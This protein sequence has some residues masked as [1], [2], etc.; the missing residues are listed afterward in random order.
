VRVSPFRQ[1]VI[2]NLIGRGSV[3]LLGIAFIPL[4]LRF[5]GI[6]AYGLV[7]FY[8]MLQGVLGLLDLGLGATINRELARLSVGGDRRADQRAILRTLEACYWATSLAAGIAIVT[9]ATPIARHWVNPSHLSLEVVASALRLMGFVIALQF[10]FS[11]YQSAMLGLQRQ[12]ALNGVVI[13]TATIRS[14]GTALVLWKVSATIEAF[15]VCQVAVSVLQTGWTAALVWSALGG[16]FTTTPDASRLRDVKGYA[17]A[18]SASSLIGIA[19][20]QLDKVLLTKLLPLEQFGYYALAG[21]MASF[22]WAIAIPVHQ[23]L[24]PRFAQLVETGDQ[25]ALALLYHR[26][27]QAMAL[28]LAPA[29]GVVGLFSWY[30]I[31]AWTRNATTADQT[32][33]IAS[34]LIAGTA[35]NAIVSVPI[36]L[37]AAAGWPQLMV[38]TNVVAASLLVPTLLFVTPR[39]GATGAAFVWLVLN[40][41]YVVFN[42]PLMHRRLLRG[43]QWRWYR[44]DLAKPLLAA[45][46]VAVGA[47]CM[48]PTPVS[49]PLALAWLAGSWSCAVLACALVE[50]EIRPMLLRRAAALAASVGG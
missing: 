29:A 37:Q 4:Y 2:A 10:P 44:D 45:S 42:V 14:A 23:A 46:A 43:E 8:A 24:F 17:V 5:L 27:S 35:L 21:T 1:N 39:Y 30:V 16:V 32:S 28:A 38:Y 48:M 20:T 47:R 12:V 3:T 34:L 50:D 11:F 6:E 18:T 9:L 22:V 40:A 41:G 15:F 25:T 36:Y 33:V 26:A 13:V 31:F 49:M 7:G 19:L